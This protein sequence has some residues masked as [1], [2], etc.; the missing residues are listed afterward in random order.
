MRDTSCKTRFYV[1]SSRHNLGAAS[2]FTDEELVT[3]PN[4]VLPGCCFPFLFLSRDARCLQ[5]RSCKSQYPKRLN[6]K[7]GQDS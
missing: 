2:D 5:N 4:P 3:D 1:N 7:A 6:C